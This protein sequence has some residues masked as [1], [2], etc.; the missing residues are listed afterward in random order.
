[1]SSNTTFPNSSVTPT[2]C[3]P[4]DDGSLESLSQEDA[5][6]LCFPVG[7]IFTDKN[8]LHEQVNKLGV[9]YFCVLNNKATST[10]RCA[11]F[12]QTKRYGENKRQKVP[13]LKSNCNWLLRFKS[14]V[15]TGPH[16]RPRFLPGDAVEITKTDFTHSCDPCP[17]KFLTLSNRAGKYTK[18]ISIDA[19][20]H[21]CS[22]LDDNPRTN[23]REIRRYLDRISPNRAKHWTSQQVWY[24]KV[25]ILA[26]L[27]KMPAEARSSYEVFRSQNTDKQFEKIFENCDEF[28]SI[29]DEAAA[30]AKDI[31]RTVMNASSE[32]DGDVT[33]LLT[34]LKEMKKMYDGFDYRVSYE[35]GTNRITG[36]VWMTSVMRAS[37]IKY[38]TYITL[39]AMKHELNT[40]HWPYIAPTLKRDDDTICVGCEAI[41]VA[42]AHDAYTWVV[43]SMYEMAPAAKKED[44]LIVSADG[45][46]NQKFVHD[47]LMLTN[48]YFVED[49]WH[50]LFSVLPKFFGVFKF[51][52]MRSDVSAMIYAK[53]ENE[54]NMR[55]NHVH[56]THIGTD[57]VLH[58]K[59][60]EF[61]KRKKHFAYHII[62]HLPGCLHL[63]GSVPSEQNHSSVK[64]NLGK[65]YYASADCLIRDLLH[66]HNF[67]NLKRSDKL[68]KASLRLKFLHDEL[69]PNE[70]ELLAASAGTLSLTGYE[71]WKKEYIAAKK[72][73]NDKVVNDNGE[74]MVPISTNSSSRLSII[75]SE[76]C[77]VHWCKGR[78]HL[79]QC[80]HKIYKNN[81]RFSLNQSAARWKFCKMVEKTK[82]IE[83]EFSPDDDIDGF[84][85]TENIEVEENIEMVVDAGG[86][87]DERMIGDSVREES[88]MTPSTKYNKLTDLTRELVEITCRSDND[89]AEMIGGMLVSMKEV[90]LQGN[91]ETDNTNNA[92]QQMMS[93]WRQHCARF[94]NGN[95]VPSAP[96]FATNSSQSAIR[97][98]RTVRPIGLA[99]KRYTSNRK[100]SQWQS[101]AN[102]DNYA[103][104]RNNP[105]VPAILIPAHKQT[106]QCSFCKGTFKTNTNHNIKT[107]CPLLHSYGARVSD[108]ST[109][110]SS[111]RTSYP[112]GK[113]VTTDETMKQMTKLRMNDLKH[114]LVHSIHPRRR[115][116]NNHAFQDFDEIIM[117]G[118]AI[119]DTGHITKFYDK[120]YICGKEFDTIISN[121]HKSEQRFLFD[122]IKD[123]S[124]GDG[125]EERS[126]DNGIINHP[127]HNQM[128]QYNN[129]QHSMP[130]PFAFDQF[131]QSFIPQ[132]QNF[133]NRHNTMLQYLPIQTSQIQPTIGIA[134][135]QQQSQSQSTQ[136]PDIYKD[137][138]SA[139]GINL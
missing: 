17:Q 90:A 53:D 39:D 35:S 86:N 98:K 77:P 6:A 49:I 100:K 104:S 43:N 116:K 38:G 126:R 111:I 73:N 45:A 114:L 72:L 32:S 89:I 124:S 78:S 40:L 62:H 66:R 37:L 20:F 3:L 23:T 88:S 4:V 120:V 7:G 18:S 21:L 137:Q 51:E 132:H 107:P 19:K 83:L 106:K 76:P 95:N 82:R 139:G 36:F 34:F 102:T 14:H 99:E 26:M 112:Y 128:Q 110:R 50:L 31:W 135:F 30:A 103:S 55:A 29:S 105:S 133:M 93:L 48:A 52:Q 67:Q 119:G 57:A 25:N 59:F 24:I 47:N 108:I 8:T 84:G 16:R 113:I 33:I 75:L 15:Y 94:S 54:F 85:R 71:L 125:Y 10:L 44:V 13:S 109:F 91:F 123:S 56:S 28:K 9:K 81:L 74:I 58:T 80:R 138:D 63:L 65:D 1:M 118:S 60:G 129:L 117:R 96:T 87:E 97:S 22:M 11:C 101:K 5:F 131:Q 61:L 130:N 69:S 121:I 122:N 115:I 46:L 2:L 64:A 42:E 12:G 92:K 41:T 136:E 70:T 79:L 134:Q 127:G 27:R 68:F